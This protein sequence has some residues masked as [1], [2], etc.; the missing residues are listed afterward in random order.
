MSFEQGVLHLPL[1][2]S[3]QQEAAKWISLDWSSLGKRV[4]KWGNF[5]KVGLTKRVVTFCRMSQLTGG[6]IVNMGHKFHLE[7]I[8]GCMFT[9]DAR[10]VLLPRLSG[11]CGRSGLCVDCGWV[12]PFLG[13]WGG[14]CGL[15]PGSRAR[16]SRSARAPR[17]P[18]FILLGSFSD[19]LL[20]V[21]I[22]DICS[23]FWSP[24]GVKVNSKYTRTKPIDA[25]AVSFGV[26]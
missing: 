14:G 23:H 15:C 11:G 9:G 19:T 7:S 16:R 17:L 22:L 8:W 4:I 25:V 26:N 24:E 20:V 10:S 21:S 1:I 12:W 3:A 5:Y 13:C 18:W 6:L 2:M